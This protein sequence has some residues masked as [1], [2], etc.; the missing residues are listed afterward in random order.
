MKTSFHK[1]VYVSKSKS[2]KVILSS[3]SNTETI[4][5]SPI[6]PQSQQV[7]IKNRHRLRVEGEKIF[8]E[9]KTMGYRKITNYAEIFASSILFVFLKRQKTKIN[10][11]V[12]RSA[13]VESQSYKQKVP[14]K[15]SYC[16]K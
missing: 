10:Q 14:Y 3:I 4:F 2:K 15:M 12:V 9:L 11:T 16:D 5:Q 1:I 13:K 7:R 8:A 6:K